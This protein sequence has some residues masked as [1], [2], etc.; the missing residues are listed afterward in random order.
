MLFSPLPIPHWIGTFAYF[1]RR[2]GL[3][4]NC[5]LFD[6]KLLKVR[7]KGMEAIKLRIQEVGLKKNLIHLL[8]REFVSK[9]FWR[10]RKNSF[11]GNIA[12]KV[13]GQHWVLLS[14]E[15]VASLMEEVKLEAINNHLEN[16]ATHNFP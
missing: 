15:E 2:W 1:V 12:L 3:A 6:M 7:A 16:H 10:P 13:F 11:K 4:K 9:I 14:L 8:K 5:S